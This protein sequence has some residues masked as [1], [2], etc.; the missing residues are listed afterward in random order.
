[1]HLSGNVNVINTSSTT[2]EVAWDPL[3]NAEMHGLRR[4]YD[5]QCREVDYP[6]FGKYPTDGTNPTNGT[7]V[8]TWF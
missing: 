5:I 3:S 4:Q 2:P 6:V 1:M 7:N 8:V